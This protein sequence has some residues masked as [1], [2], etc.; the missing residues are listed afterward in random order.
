[1]SKTYIIDGNSLLFRS[2]YATYR[3]GVEIMRAQDGTPTNALFTFYPMLEHIKNSLTA[4]DR[5]IVCFDTG[6]PTFRTK[7]IEGY[8]AQRKPIEPDLKK[9]IPLAHEMCKC[10]G[11]ETAEMEGYEGDDVAG[12]LAKYAAR[13]GDEV[14]L[15]TSDKDFLQLIDDHIQVHALKRG[16][17]DVFTYTKENMVE[18]YGV[19]ADQVTD[20]K[21]IAGDASDNYKGIPH[22]GEKTAKSLLSKYNHLEDILTA[23]RGKSDTAL[24][25]NLNAGADEGRLCLKIATI[26]TDLDVA[27][28]YNRG[29]VRPED[30]QA[31]LAF[32]NRFSL[33][34]Y[35]RQISN[36]AVKEDEKGT[37]SAKLDVTNA[38]VKAENIPDIA[39]DCLPI[40][41]SAILSSENENTA[42]ILGFAIGYR[43]RT[44]KLIDSFHMS[45]ATNL[46]RFLADPTAEKWS[47]DS[48][49]TIVAAHRLGF[50]AC[51]FT[52]DFLL[53][54]YLI[55]SDRAATL[56][57]AF[58]QIDI[59]LPPDPTQRYVNATAAMIESCASL[60]ASLKK[61]DAEKLLTTVEIP[62]AKTLADME[63]EGL[64]L[65]LKELA[66]IGTEY[67]KLLKDLEQQIYQLAGT[68]FNIKSPM[69]VADILFNRLGLPKG[70]KE[71][72]TSIEVLNNHYADHPIIPLIIQYRTYAKIISGYIDA[73]PKHVLSDGK[74]HA[75]INQTLTSTGRLSCS[76]PNLQNISIRKE[77]GKE[78]RKAF[79]Y[80]DDDFEFLSLDYSQVELRVLASLGNIKN[81]IAVCNSGEDIHKATASMVFNVPIDE[82]TPEMRRKAKT[83]NFGIVYGIST[84]GLKERLGISFEEAKLIISAFKKTFEG[85]DEYESKVKDFAR[86]NGYVKTILNRRRYFPDINSSN[87]MKRAFSER[88]AINATI[89]GSAADLI[90]VA[91][92]KVSELLKGKRTKIV[93]QIHDELVFKMAKDE[94]KEL[95]PL[96]A[97][98]MDEALPLSVKQTVEGSTGHSWFDCK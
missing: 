69:Q 43:D 89:Q 34:K 28:F 65:D 25:R 56:E 49:S 3:P 76:E 66:R 9:Q 44:V 80:P 53:A 5:M 42:D 67:R 21:A 24:A 60:L 8:K 7:E 63:I 20:F 57:D 26:V 47:L 17:S 1:M 88:A 22:I 82:V 62:L 97:K 35:A 4:E 23:Y 87:P 38:D 54:S 48:K 73:L 64:P 18:S 51:G 91:M 29:A 94:E 10:M 90:K 95:I 93:V 27:E 37:K 71:S 83:V 14:V 85:M 74:I 52:F 2:F 16:L 11:I 77:E 98:T 13:Q 41:V 12:S 58:S 15:F 81:L 78:I 70:K 39:P 68:E 84:Y 6:H 61:Q 36:E 46:K 75:K 32:M 79:F 19:R 86:K 33:E 72:G 30:T 92:I 31:V 45:S 40:A 50:E 96:I 55:N 59:I